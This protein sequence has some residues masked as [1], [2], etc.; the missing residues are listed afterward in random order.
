MLSLTD[1]ATTMKI[2]FFVAQEVELQYSSRIQDQYQVVVSE[3]IF[4]LSLSLFGALEVSKDKYWLSG[5]CWQRNW[6]NLS[7]N[8]NQDNRSNHYNHNIRLRC[9]MRQLSASL[10]LSQQP[11]RWLWALETSYFFCACSTF[12]KSSTSVLYNA[13]P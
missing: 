2:V 6:A 12:I 5:G 7:N 10:E 9:S 3:H 11:L 4:S 1:L 8:H 13:I